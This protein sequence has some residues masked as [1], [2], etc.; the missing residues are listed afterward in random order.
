MRAPEPPP[1][2]PIFSFF[3]LFSPER[4]VEGRRRRLEV[5]A[6][7]EG[8]RLPR[9][10]HPVHAGILP[11]N[12]ERTV[13]A[14]AVEDSDHRLEVHAPARDRTEVPTSAVVAEGEVRGED[15]ALAVER[16]YGVLHMHVVDPVGEAVPELPR[17]PALTDQG[18][19][20]EV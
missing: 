11:L 2:I 12:G 6:P 8:G 3:M 7:N 16:P 10:V 20:A 4:G 9:S 18:A 1:T 13:I 14:D 17:V 5:H 15:A 19:G